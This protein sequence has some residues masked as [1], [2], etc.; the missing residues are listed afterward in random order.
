MLDATVG[1]VN[2]YSAGQQ[3]G[4]GVGLEVNQRSDGQRR[5][6][7]EGGVVAIGTIAL[8]DHIDVVDS[9][10]VVFNIALGYEFGLSDISDVGD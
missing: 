10:I 2:H 1:T 9:I 3:T 5:I 8:K 4:G 6:G 7:V